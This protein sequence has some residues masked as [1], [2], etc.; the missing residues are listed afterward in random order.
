MAANDEQVADWFS[1]PGDS[2]RAGMQRRGLSAE[3]L[4][5]H[6][7]NGM[8]EVREL[9]DGSR[10]IDGPVAR[11]LSDTLGGSE[12]F[13]LKRQENFEKALQNAVYE[14]IES[15]EKWLEKVPM[16]RVAGRRTKKSID[17]LQAEVRRRMI[18]YNVPT[19]A[20]WERRYGEIKSQT[21]FRQSAAFK[22]ENDSVLL[23]LRRGEI[24]AGMVQTRLW[25]PGNLQDRL[26]AI[27]SLTK[28]SQPFRFLPKLRALCAEAGVALVVV[29]T[30]QGCHAS[31]ATRLVSADKA[32]LLLSFRHRADDQF[33]FTVFHEI[34]HLLLHSAET[35]VDDA[36]T[37]TNQFEDEANDFAQRCIIPAERK[38]EFEELKASR[39]A[40]L[41][42]SIAAG[43]A[44]GLTVGQM[45]YRGKI[46][47][48]QMNHLKRRWAWESIDHTVV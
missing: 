36:D 45:Q 29:R 44:P 16:P 42:F 30:P 4:A 8:S 35:F 40:I 22:P 34:G 33:W 5:S 6:F 48:S 47:H 10:S 31:G 41:R 12:D 19:L 3:Q 27:R 46:K 7:D 26:D 15:A 23:W 9:L 13:W 39:E 28:I 1:K 11:V 20:S 18:F 14:E 17:A 21:H 2:V 25:S 32:M 37:P 24:E 43:I 38:Q